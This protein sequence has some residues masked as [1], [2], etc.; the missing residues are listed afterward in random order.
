ILFL[1]PYF[2]SHATSA[3]P[4]RTHLSLS[5]GDWSSAIALFAY[6]AA[7][8]FAYNS[9]SAGTGALVL[10]GAVQATMILWGFSRGERLDVF[11]LA[12]LLVALA[13]LVVLLLPGLSAPSLSGSLLMLAAGVAWGAYSLRGRGAIDPVA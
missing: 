8:S 13:G 4:A 2:L 1:R 11:Q 12:G 3:S 7:F 9:L 5:C 10:F 6:A